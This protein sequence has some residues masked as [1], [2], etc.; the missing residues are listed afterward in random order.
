MGV[1]G[2]EPTDL[3]GCKPGDLTRLDYTPVSYKLC[4]YSQ[5][6]YDICKF[7]VRFSQNLLLYP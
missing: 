2:F 6:S 7:F 5:F 1:A 3:P 4:K